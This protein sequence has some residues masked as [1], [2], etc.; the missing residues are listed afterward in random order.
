MAWSEWL[1]QALILPPHSLTVTG[2]LRGSITPFEIKAVQ[3]SAAV[4]VENTRC[5]ISNCGRCAGSMAQM[6]PRRLGRRLV[7]G[8]SSPQVGGQGTSSGVLSF[9]AALA[10]LSPEGVPLESRFGLAVAAFINM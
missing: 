6:N 3:S 7:G 1:Y 8:L 4:G 10:L 9:T 2:T 5:H